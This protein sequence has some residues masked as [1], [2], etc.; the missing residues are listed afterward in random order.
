MKYIDEVAGKKSTHAVRHFEVLQPF[1]SCYT[2]LCTHRPQYRCQHLATA[3][4]GVNLEVLV[5]TDM[6]ES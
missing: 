2:Q 4:T 1:Q 5:F 3:H 6:F